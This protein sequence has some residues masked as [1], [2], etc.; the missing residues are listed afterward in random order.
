M[1]TTTGD[2][3]AYAGLLLHS[4]GIN[5]PDI[6]D[7]QLNRIAQMYPDMV[8]SWVDGSDCGRAMNHFLSHRRHKK[9]PILGGLC[10]CGYKGA[11][12]GALTF[13]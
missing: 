8:A 4:P 2:G 7:P 1:L 11:V 13:R 5:L 9:A 10:Y 12:S 3:Q 6:L